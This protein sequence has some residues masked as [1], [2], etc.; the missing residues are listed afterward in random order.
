M[1][2]RFILSEE[3][4]L[5]Y[6]ELAKLATGGDDS[7]LWKAVIEEYFGLGEIE[8]PTQA[9]Q[10]LVKMVLEVFKKRRYYAKM[11]KESRERQKN[12]SDN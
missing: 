8:Q 5:Q 3:D 11:K 1:S 12:E 7:W 2:K 6:G 4:Y 10:N 9:R